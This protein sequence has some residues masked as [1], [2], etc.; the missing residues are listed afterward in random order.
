MGVGGL[1]C[2]LQSKVFSFPS[3]VG[4]A[5]A[6]SN[7]SE[8]RITK[9][10]EVIS[11]IQQCRCCSLFE[12]KGNT[13]G[14]ER[15]TVHCPWSICFQD[16]CFK[17]DGQSKSSRNGGTVM[18][19]HTA[20]IFTPWPESTSELY[21]PSGRRLSVTLV[22][23]FVDR[24]CHVA[25]VTD[26]YGRIFDFLDQPRLVIGIYLP[27]FTFYISKLWSLFVSKTWF[28]QKLFR[29]F[30]STFYFSHPKIIV[31]SKPEIQMWTF[32]I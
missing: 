8:H 16:L 30:K 29:H 23:S 6:H 25:S 19:G 20:T 9:D 31:S 11:I 24:G 22:P 3:A 26:P 18:V 13:H 27:S 21:W 7:H 1:R 32:R 28:L 4:H 2:A 10:Q 12:H 5:I 17:Y 15:G 14:I